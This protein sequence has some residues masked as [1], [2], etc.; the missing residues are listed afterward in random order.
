MKPSHKQL[1]KCFR[2]RSLNGGDLI[3]RSLL[4]VNCDNW[5]GYYKNTDNQCA[6]EAWNDGW[7]IVDGN[8]VCNHQCINNDVDSEQV[9]ERQP[10]GWGDLN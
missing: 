2:I 4:C 7:R 5:I 3:E 6:K 9:I 1:I 10:A 8:T